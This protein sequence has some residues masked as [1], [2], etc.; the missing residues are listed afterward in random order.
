MHRFYGKSSNETVKLP[1][2]PSPKPGQPSMETSPLEPPRLRRSNAIKRI[3]EALVNCR[4]EGARAESPTPTG[5]IRPFS[6]T[7]T[8]GQDRIN[9]G[10]DHVHNANRVIGD[11]DIPPMKDEWTWEDMRRLPGIL[12]SFV[13]SGM[14]A[15]ELGFYLDK[16]LYGR[17]RS[18]GGVVT[19]LVNGNVRY[20]EIAIR[21]LKLLDLYDDDG[22]LLSEQ[23]APAESGSR[24]RPNRPLH[25][26]VTH[27]QIQMQTPPISLYDCNEELLSYN[28][29]D[30]TGPEIICPRPRHV[31]LERE[32][33]QCSLAE[34]A[35]AHATSSE[36]E[37]ED[38][39]QDPFADFD[40]AFDN[41]D[42]INA[43]AYAGNAYD[44]N[45]SSS[46]TSP[47]DDDV[48]M[49]DAQAIRYINPGPARICS[50]CYD[51]GSSMAAQA[52]TNNK[53]HNASGVPEELIPGMAA[54][55]ELK[56]ERFLID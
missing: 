47:F 5:R 29:P 51:D 39:E 40:F 31:A 3:G 13:K 18:V 20:H 50:Q 35:D 48:A 16:M 53:Q 37:D 42:N 32:C 38:G 43:N 49:Q 46:S 56:R 34:D 9:A 17:D 19:T 44:P 55:P 10:A 12:I 24:R 27:R 41:T 8:D 54:K 14:P 33:I 25:Y 22:H 1:R 11:I 36:D 52:N 15:D 28:D 4:R 30:T 7:R 26:K 6:S 23:I 2:T 45:T 21:T